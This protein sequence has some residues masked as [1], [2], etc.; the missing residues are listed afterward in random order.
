[1]I[2]YFFLTVGLLF[3]IVGAQAQETSKAPPKVIQFSGIVVT[4]D[5]LTPVPYTSVYRERDN[6][7]TITDFYG[8]FSLP[9]YEG[10]TIRFTC[11]GLAD[12][13]FVIP[14]TLTANRYNV[15]QFMTVDT[16]QIPATFIYPWPAPEK[17]KEEFLALELPDSEEER[18]RKNLESVM[19]YDRMIEMGADGSENYKIAVQEQTQRNYWAGQTPPLSVFNPIAWAKFIEAWQNGDF[20]EEK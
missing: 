14:D 18:A 17:F 19:M 6:R 11:V 1:M 16:V 3:L 7:G 8:F 13:E 2:R 5:S 10:D 15:V 4:G 20:K 9:T 12:A